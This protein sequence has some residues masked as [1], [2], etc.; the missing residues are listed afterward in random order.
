MDLRASGGNSDGSGDEDAAV[1]GLPSWDDWG[2]RQPRAVPWPAAEAAQ[3]A[4]LRR[5]VR[6]HDGYVQRT[7][8]WYDL[9]AVTLGGA[10]IGSAMECSGAYG[11]FWSVVVSKVKQRLDL[12][13]F[14]GDVAACWWGVL[15]EDVLAAF[16]AAELETAVVGDNICITRLRHHRYS[17][18]GYAVV[19]F[20]RD[21]ETGRLVLWHSD[22]D[23]DDVEEV[24]TVLL[25]FKCPLSRKLTGRVPG[26]YRCQ[27]ESGLA[28]SPV[29]ALGLYVEGVF[30]KC[31]LAQ[32]GGGDGYDTDYHAAD[33]GRGRGAFTGTPAA[34]GLIGVYA[35]TAA[36]PQAVRYGW[37]GP[38][39]APGDP[40]PE[41]PDADAADA[42][43]HIRYHLGAAAGEPADLGAA[44][45]VTFERALR[46][47]DRG[48]FR[49]FRAAP[50]L[51]GGRGRPLEL[52]PTLRL[53][54]QV[55]PAVCGRAAPWGLVAVIPWK[56]W[57]AD[58]HVVRRRPGFADE[59]EDI[60]AQVME[61]VEEAMEAPDPLAYVTD[62]ATRGRV[63]AGWG[64]SSKVS[65]A[66]LQDLFDAMPG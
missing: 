66:A 4:N 63:A 47:I 56:L 21:A 64:G 28:V 5:F 48:R 2:P 60:A 19:R 32:L 16:V 30:R 49:V 38:E 53:L 36:A 13:S 10:E 7:K 54:A 1:A 29:A 37:A 27:V 8:P 20:R 39:W 6:L 40:D 3:N 42:A 58:F 11:D 35:P 44:D 9:M 34:W 65:G 18:D 26:G 41:E 57:R 31:A 50:A 14:N 24:M 23:I 43:W 12:P 17:P 62:Q 55:A 46:L 61:A 45:K 22:E 59:M 25:E 52:A 33:L 15:F 51:A